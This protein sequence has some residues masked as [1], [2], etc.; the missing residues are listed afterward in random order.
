MFQIVENIH[1][2]EAES[3]RRVLPLQFPTRT[4]A[5]EHIEMLQAQFAHRGRNKEQDY[6]WARNDGGIELYR[7]WIED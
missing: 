1:S 7:W 4:A 2:G 3:S 5:I 6:W